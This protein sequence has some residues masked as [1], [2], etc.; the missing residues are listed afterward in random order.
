MAAKPLWRVVGVTKAALGKFAELNYRYESGQGLKRA[1]LRP[2]IETVRELLSRSEPLSQSEFIEYWVAHDR[3]VLCAEGENK[4]TVPPFIEIENSD[5][6]LFPT[7][8]V[9]WRHGAKERELLRLLYEKSFSS[10]SVERP[11]SPT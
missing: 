2:R 4:A 5:G 7:T 6:S 3:V 1:H 10:A 9:K 8:A 11:Q